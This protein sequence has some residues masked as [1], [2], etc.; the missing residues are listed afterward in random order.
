[1]PLETMIRYLTAG[2]SHGPA[3]TAIIEGVPAGL[4]LSPDVINQQLH[5]RQQGYGRGNRMKIET[6]TVEVLS[7]VRF[8]KTIGSPITLLIR[9][10]DWKNWTEKMNQ[11]EDKQSSVKTVAVPRPGHADFSGKLKYGFDDIRPVIERSSARETAARVAACTVARAFLKSLGIEIG[12]YLS[13]IG[14]AIEKNPN[15]NIYALLSAGAETLANEADRS[16]VRMLNAALETEAMTLIDDAK[17]RGDTLGGIIEVFV[18]GLPIGLGSYAQFDRKLDGELG[19][20]V[21]SIQAVKGVEIG[22]AFQNAVRFGSE[23]HDE[24]FLD[25][26]GKPY[27]KTNRAGGLEGGMTNGEVLQLRVAMKPISTLMNPLHSVN[28]ETMEETNSHIERSDTCAAPACAVIA[29]AVI[30]PVLANAVLEKF[31]GDSMPEVLARLDNYRADL[32]AAFERKT[33]VNT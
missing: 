10:A 24:I 14:Q 22:T 25:E 9:N 28:L 12:S 29:E 6:D 13:A 20:A 2:E 11:F 1:M 15:E 26:H 27:R 19:K 21:L 33:P 16:P 3:L 23:V 31:G 5:R 4:A 7:G 17:K 18:T 32:N 8:G 30:A